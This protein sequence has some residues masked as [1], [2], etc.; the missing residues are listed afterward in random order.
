M[1]LLAIAFPVSAFQGQ[2]GSAFL[3]AAVA[4]LEAAWEISGNPL[5]ELSLQELIDCIPNAGGCSGGEINVEAIMDFVQKHGLCSAAA[6]PSTGTQGKCGQAA[7][8]PT[9][10]AGWVHNATLVTPNSNGAMLEAVATTVVAVA[11][12]ADPLQF[13][14][15]GVFTGP[16]ADTVDHALAVVGYGTSLSGTDYW[17]LKNSW[18]TSWGMSGYLQ[19]GR[20]LPA[21]QPSGLCGVLSAGSYPGH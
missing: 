1:R 6:Y 10:P 7:C 14:T 15:S 11:V 5:T 4:T 19:L 21:N 18:G 2:C 16:C 20:A 9:I 3:Y 17:F 8:T 13:Y 12:D